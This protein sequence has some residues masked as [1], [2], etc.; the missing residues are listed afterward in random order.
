MSHTLTYSTLPNEIKTIA[1]RAVGRG[2][3]KS[4]FNHKYVYHMM[5]KISGEDFVGFALYHFERHHT[6]PSG[7]DEYVGVIDCVCIDPDLQ[8]SGYG[9]LLTFSVIRKL[10]VCGA[11]QV[12]MRVKVPQSS[13]SGTRRRKSVQQRVDEFMESMGFTFTE[14]CDNYYGKVSLKYRYDCILC[15]ALPDACSGMLYNID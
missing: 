2:V 6:S 3:L 12:D 4:L 14:T 10:S 8:K 9:T 15:H 7:S 11:V 1:N 13:S 5:I